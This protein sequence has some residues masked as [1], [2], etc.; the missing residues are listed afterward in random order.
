MFDRK[1]KHESFIT[2]LDFL[3]QVE[4]EVFETHVSPI[5]L[6][7]HVPQFFRNVFQVL[8]LLFF[9]DT[10]CLICVSLSE[11]TFQRLTER[12][13]VVHKLASWILCVAIFQKWF[14]SVAFVF[15]LSHVRFDFYFAVRKIAA[16]FNR[17]W[18]RV[19]F[20]SD[21]DFLCRNFPEMIFSCCSCFLFVAHKVWFLFRCRK[22][23]VTK[24]QHNRFVCSQ[25]VESEMNLSKS[26]CTCLN[27][28]DIK[29][30]LHFLTHKQTRQMKNWTVRKKSSLKI[31]WPLRGHHLQCTNYFSCV[32]LP[33]HLDPNPMT[34]VA[35]FQK[36]FSKAWLI[37]LLSG[38]SISLFYSCMDKMQ[39][40]K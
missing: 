35:I 30:F 29:P 5:R 9:C 7:K 21:L 39:C 11:K 34:C 20:I 22:K 25:Q 26:T 13:Q 40:A 38:W 23:V 17:K 33:A 31:S 36:W 19:L 15:L 3:V 8:L 4:T 28:L 24:F 18:K 27:W 1:W 14:S 32:F 12:N 37:F 10:T 16:R 2:C 6:E